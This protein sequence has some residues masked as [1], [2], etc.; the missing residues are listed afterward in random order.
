MSTLDLQG[1]W[2]ATLSACDTAQGKRALEKESWAWERLY[3]S[4]RTEPA[5]DALANLR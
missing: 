5:N 4:W 1:T 2:L 3:S